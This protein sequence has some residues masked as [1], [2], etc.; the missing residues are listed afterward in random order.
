MGRGAMANITDLVNTY[1]VP[2]TIIEVGVFEGSTTFWMSDTLTPHNKNL[3]IHA[4]D[5]HTGSI[6]MLEDFT[7]VKA[8]FV[9]NLSVSTHKNVNYISKP[10]KVGLMDLINADTKAELIYMVLAWEILVVGGVILCDDT[11]TW[12][13]ADKNGTMSAQMSPRMAVEMFIQCNWHKLKIL[14][15]PDGSQTAIMKVSE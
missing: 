11:T 2:N 4:V 9:H 8:A 1:G 14:A 15:L 3:L 12:R 6:D 7:D 10:S 5:P 13:Y